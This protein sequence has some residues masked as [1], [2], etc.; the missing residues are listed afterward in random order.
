M[1]VIQL[2]PCIDMG[3]CAVKSTDYFIVTQHTTGGC[4]YTCIWSNLIGTTCAFIHLLCVVLQ[5]NN[6]CFWLHMVPCLYMGPCCI[7]SFNVWMRM[8]HYLIQAMMHE[9]ARGPNH[10]WSY[11]RVLTSTFCVLCYNEIICAFDCTWSH[12]YTWDQLYNKH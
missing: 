8:S 11:T 5:W 2:V 9:C 1:L 7:T 4:K 6:L 12:V 3:P 10:I